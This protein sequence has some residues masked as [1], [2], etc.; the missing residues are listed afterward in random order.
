MLSL[1]LRQGDSHRQDRRLTRSHG[2]REEDSGAGR[3]SP[4]KRVCAT[5]PRTADRTI[6]NLRLAAEELFDQDRRIR[7][8]DVNPDYAMRPEREDT[9]AV[10]RQ[11]QAAGSKA[12]S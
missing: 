6:R 7:A 10:V 8:A 12:T 1:A 9:V 11:L 4:V 2:I 3:A 5:C